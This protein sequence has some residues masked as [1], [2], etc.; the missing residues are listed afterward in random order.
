MLCNP[1]RC[2][3]VI[4]MSLNHVVS[5]I[6]TLYLPQ[7]TCCS[8]S[9]GTTKISYRDIFTGLQ[10][11]YWMYYC[12]IYVRFTKRHWECYLKKKNYIFITILDMW[13]W[14]D[15][16]KNPLPRNLIHN[17]TQWRDGAVWR[18]ELPVAAVNF[19]IFL[20]QHKCFIPLTLRR[21][22]NTHHYLFI[23]LSINE[24][25]IMLFF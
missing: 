2:V 1:P 19:I 6:R 3:W 14:Y 13:L 18:S 23:S 12:A 24:R 11:T 9:Y 22:S 8:R 5:V 17:W 4:W 15:K 21:F 10:V 25:H 7:H 20:Q 16:K